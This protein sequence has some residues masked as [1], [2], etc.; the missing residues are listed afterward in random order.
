MAEDHPGLQGVA[1]GGQSGGRDDLGEGERLPQAAGGV[2]EDDDVVFGTVQG[3]LDVELVVGVAVD[4]P[5][6]A[7]FEALDEGGAQAVVAAARVAD[8]QD[9][10]RRTRRSRAQRTF[11]WRTWPSASTRLT[12]SG[13]RPTAWVA[14]LRH[15]S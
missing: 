3:V 10:H 6:A 8:P 13:I 15:G 2:D 1:Q 5:E 9:E 14:Q 11:L 7:L 12:S 4:A